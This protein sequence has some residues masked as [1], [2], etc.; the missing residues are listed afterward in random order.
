MNGLVSR[1]Q[2]IERKA[3]PGDPFEHLTDEE[4]E[5]AIAAVKASIEAEFGMSEP[6]LA[7]RFEKDLA[8]G[9]NSYGV[10]PQAM[11]CFV[12]Q[13]KREYRPNA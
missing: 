3:R 5:A 1:L 8:S 11:R 10:D 12:D 13:V 6:E 4:L 9:E 2:R 7:G